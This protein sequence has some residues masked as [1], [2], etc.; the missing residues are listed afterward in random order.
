M[1]NLLDLCKESVE[2]VPATMDGPDG[3]WVPVLMYEDRNGKVHLAA[4]PDLT[5]AT[6]KGA[7]TIIGDKLR[8]AEAV[9]ASLVLPT[10]FSELA[11]PEAPRVERILITHVD[12]EETTCEAAKVIRSETEKPR[13]GRWDIYLRDI[14]VGAGVFVDAMRAAI[15]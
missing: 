3:D 5:P 14:D 6:V 1:V 8:A 2:I 10:W 15:G 12:R 9:Q 7:A 11:D 4:I 13:L